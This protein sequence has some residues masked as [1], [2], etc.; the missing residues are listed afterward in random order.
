MDRSAL[1]PDGT[2]VSIYD[3]DPDESFTGPEGLSNFF[4][5]ESEV[6]DLFTGEFDE[7]EYYDGDGSYQ[8]EPFEDSTPQRTVPREAGHVGTGSG[9]TQ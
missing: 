9:L 3:E 5:E 1:D 2:S 8:P 4:N 7:D 6:A